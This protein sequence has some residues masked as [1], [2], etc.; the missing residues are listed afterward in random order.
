VTFSSCD[1]AVSATT[2]AD[3][4]AR[5][6]YLVLTIGCADC[7]TPRGPDGQELP[8]LEL[9]GHP[10]DAPLPSWEPSLL[11][12]NGVATISPTGTAFAGPFGVS[13]APN[14]TPCPDTG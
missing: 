12:H 2:Q 10:A 1:R 5:G 14:L 4:V 6:R 3:P 11:D 7:H 9:S 8:G 13:V